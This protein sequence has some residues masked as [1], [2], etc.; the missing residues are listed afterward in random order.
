MPDKRGRSTLPTGPIPLKMKIYTSLICLF[1]TI[2]GLAEAFPVTVRSCDDVL[3]VEK[4]PERV[5][6]LGR[7]AVE[8]VI[9]IGGASSLVALSVGNGTDQLLPEL[10]QFPTDIVELDHSTTA[11]NDISALEPDLVVSSWRDG[12][13][14]ESSVNPGALSL[15]GIQTFALNGSCSTQTDGERTLLEGVND[16]TTLGKILDVEENASQLH[17][18]ISAEIKSIEGRSRQIEPAT[19]LALRLRDERLEVADLSTHASALLEAAGGVNLYASANRG[20]QVLEPAALTSEVPDVIV[21]IQD[22]DT[23]SDAITEKLRAVL[24]DQG[25]WPDWSSRL[26]FEASLDVQPSLRTSMTLWRL[27]RLMEERRGR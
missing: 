10:R 25:L 13:S 24:G 15:F 12:F 17:A 16:V 21:V 5:V 2:G 22:Q 3:V 14:T 1:V 8:M 23:T 7:N 26:T 9:G 19:F 27:N 6:A 18:E 11:L 4:A 20:W